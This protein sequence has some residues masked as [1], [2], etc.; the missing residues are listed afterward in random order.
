MLK[1]TEHV[2][3]LSAVPPALHLNSAWKASLL[4]LVDRYNHRWDVQVR[5]CRQ[6][7]NKQ[8]VC[9]SQAV[10][11]SCTFTP[12]ISSAAINIHLLFIII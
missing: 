2:S 5:S 4:M 10:E 9:S 7:R 6:A 12:K 8:A 11:T 3:C 1:C